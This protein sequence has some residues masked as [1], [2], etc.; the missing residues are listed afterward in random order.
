M[1]FLKDLI[2]NHS[3]LKLISVV[4][5]VLMTAAVI[6]YVFT[7]RN[8]T[9]EYAT[10]NEINKTG[11]IGNAFYELLK[12]QFR[13]TESVAGEFGALKPQTPEE[14]KAAFE[15][16]GASDFMGKLRFADSE[17]KVYESDGREYE[18]L[19]WEADLNM[20]PDTSRGFCVK[21]EDTAAFLEKALSDLGLSDTEA[22]TFIMYWLPQMEENPYN[23]ISFQTEAY[24]NAAMLE[25]DPLP[26]T[27][28]RVNMFFYASD[29]YVEIEKQDLTSMNPSLEEREG[30]VL[31]E[32]GGETV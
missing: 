13:M 29:E 25:V 7:V 22:N 17:G 31:V 19:F 5:A 10:D 27:I 28:V 4:A 18:Y 9:L 11:I 24:E 21:G 20:D 23:V 1:T 14:I 26:D 3:R 12:D 32:W 15:S 8:R 16:V 6:V 30:F 2:G